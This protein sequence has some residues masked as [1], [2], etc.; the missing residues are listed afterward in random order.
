ML[1]KPLRNSKFPEGAM[2][3][4]SKTFGIVERSTEHTQRVVF[5]DVDGDEF[6]CSLCTEDLHDDS[7]RAPTRASD[8]D[9]HDGSG[10]APKRASDILCDNKLNPSI[11]STSKDTQEKTR[12]GKRP[13]NS[14]GKFSPGAIVANS[15]N[16]ETQ[17]NQVQFQFQLPLQMPLTA[18]VN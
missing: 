7:G 15:G 11:H 4:K 5:E 16:Q 10:R 8:K 9:F 1:G 17:E 2:S 12:K 18:M 13:E 3:E 6:I 14:F